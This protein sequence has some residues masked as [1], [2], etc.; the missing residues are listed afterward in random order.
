MNIAIIDDLKEDGLLLCAY[1]KQYCDENK[2]LANIKNF[3]RASDFLACF[4]PQVYDLIFVDIYME[5][6]NGIELAQKYGKP[7]RTAS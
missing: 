2:T 3:E 6:M 5:G 4:I 1:L 7:T